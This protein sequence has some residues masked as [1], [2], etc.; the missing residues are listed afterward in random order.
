VVGILAVL[1]QWPSAAIAVVFASASALVFER[2]KLALLSRPVWG[3]RFL[4]I[5][6][7]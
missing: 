5:A 1:D 2:G 4:S 3:S 7:T 6:L